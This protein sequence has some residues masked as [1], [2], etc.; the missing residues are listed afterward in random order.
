MEYSKIGNWAIGYLEA[1]STGNVVTKLQ[2]EKMID[3]IHEMISEIE[4][5][6][7]GNRGPE[8][9]IEDDF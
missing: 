3:R 1:L 6:N 4:S 2:L 9:R 7:T 5:S 8:I